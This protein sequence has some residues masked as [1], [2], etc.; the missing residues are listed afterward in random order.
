MIQPDGIL[1]PFT[2]LNE[3][4]VKGFFINHKPN[5]F[6]LLANYN[7][8]LPFQIKRQ[9]TGDAITVFK[10]VGQGTEI[11]LM[12]DV[13]KIEIYDYVTYEWLIFT[14]VETLITTLPTTGYYYLQVADAKNTWYFDY[15]QLGNF[16]SS[17]L[18]FGAYTDFYNLYYQKNSSATGA[19]T[20]YYDIFFTRNKDMVDKIYQ[21]SYYDRLTLHR[22]DAT[23]RYVG[24][25]EQTEIDES[26]GKELVNQIFSFD[27]YELSFVINRNSANFLN[28]LK[29]LT[30]VVVILP[31]SE[32]YTA[33]DFDCEISALESDQI[34]KVIM[35]LQLNYIN[36]SDTT[37][38][39]LTS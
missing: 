24:R 37:Y 31:N 29:N 34:K 5:V 2:S 17:V 4:N 3:Q 27:E 13:A 26:T 11:D 6:P 33:Y 21:N 14:S 9:V 32:I 39:D 18:N 7:K 38:N 35:K 36:K 20:N 1:T 8:L 12:A 22:K 16:T 15:M 25:K 10:L 28:K 19:V 30:K 23:F